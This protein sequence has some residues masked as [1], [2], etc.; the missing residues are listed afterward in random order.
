MKYHPLYRP[1]PPRT[2]AIACLQKSQRANCLTKLLVF[3]LTVHVSDAITQTLRMPLQRDQPR[4]L[5]RRHAL[6]CLEK[7]LVQRRAMVLA[8]GLPVC[9]AAAL[10]QSNPAV[11]RMRALMALTLLLCAINQAK[12]LL[13]MSRP[14]Q[15]TWI[16]YRHASDFTDDEFRDHT[17][18]RK[19]DFFRCPHQQTPNV[20]L[21]MQNA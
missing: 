1:R 15:A 16:P 4:P 2:V 6:S 12:V 18:F 8:L 14:H 19:V 11:Q 17:R 9:I 5:L 10:R 21:P 7:R 20:T 3:S 13:E